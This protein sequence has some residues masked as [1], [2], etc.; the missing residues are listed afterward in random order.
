M[1]EKETLQLSSPELV[2]INRKVLYYINFVEGPFSPRAI[3]ETEAEILHDVKPFLPTDYFKA[4]QKHFLKVRQPIDLRVRLASVTDSLTQ[5]PEKGFFW[6]YYLPGSRGMGFKECSGFYVDCCNLKDFNSSEFWGHKGGDAAVTALALILREAASMFGHLPIRLGGDEFLLLFEGP[7]SRSD[8]FLQAIKA[9]SQKITPQALIQGT[10]ENRPILNYATSPPSQIR[11]DSSVYERFKEAA[12]GELAKILFPLKI[13]C[14]P[15]S[16][17][18]KA[19]PE[20]IESVLNEADKICEA[21]KAQ[22]IRELA[23]AYPHGIMHLARKV[24]P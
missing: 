7:F 22:L 16:F 15:F 24:K 2:L 23:I 10:I 1:P 12:G 8:Q 3:A 4:L 13:T 6:K 17:D 14:T 18:L 9:G 19:T 21:E 20:Q 11:L 5:L